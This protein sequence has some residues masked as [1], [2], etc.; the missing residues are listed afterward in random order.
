MSN[1]SLYIYIYNYSRSFLLRTH[2]TLIERDIYIID[3]VYTIG[4]RH[5]D[6]EIQ[7]LEINKI[8]IDALVLVVV[9]PPRTLYML[10]VCE[11]VIYIQ[12]TKTG[13]CG[14]AVASPIFDSFRSNKI[15]QHPSI[16]WIMCMDPN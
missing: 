5:I 11:C 6:M 3:F 9:V 16:Y 2:A 10:V 7:K 4:H 13:I 1:S 15:S 14:S 8:E 12:T